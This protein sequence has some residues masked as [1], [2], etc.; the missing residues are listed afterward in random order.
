MR[1]SDDCISC[2]MP[3]ARAADGLHTSFTDHS[4]PRVARAEAGSLAGGSSRY[5]A[6]FWGDSAE[7]R[8]VALAYAKVAV[9]TAKTEDYSRAFSELRLAVK[10]APA[11][12]EVLTQLGYMYEHFGDTSQAIL[13][14]QRALQQDS[15]D[16]VAGVNLAGL[17]AERGHSSEAM[18][19][20]QNALSNNPG[21]EAPGINLSE[22]YLKQGNP[23][24]AA[25]WLASVLEF[26]PDSPRAWKLWS[27]IS[28]HGGH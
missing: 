26:S 17:L 12:Y 25:K 2:H 21:L 5:L 9:R 27:A 11:D 16:D 23:E 7:I 28:S 13:L 19:L 10:E 3:K 22:L 18:Q 6:P 8:E 1:N 24:A 14:Y 20:W 4:I 15:A